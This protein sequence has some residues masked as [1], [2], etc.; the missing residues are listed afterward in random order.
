MEQTQ[1]EMAVLKSQSMG[2][3]KDLA[4]QNNQ[5][6]VQS[7]AELSVT[8]AQLKTLQLQLADQK[9]EAE[10][11]LKKELDAKQSIIQASQ[12]KI[13]QLTA[14]VSGQVTRYCLRIILRS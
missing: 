14:E 8:Q 2:T 12:A 3:I 1:E 7:T 5:S 4:M 6:L 9:A 13:D 11:R 10:N